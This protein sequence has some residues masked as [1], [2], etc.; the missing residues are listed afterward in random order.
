VGGEYIDWRTWL[1]CDR[2]VFASGSPDPDVDFLDRATASAAGWSWNASSP[3]ASA[4]GAVYSSAHG[5]SD[6]VI[7][8][9]PADSRSAA[10]NISIRQGRWAESWL[11]NCVAIGDSAV[12]I[13]PL[14]W[15]NLHLVH[16]QIDRLVSMMPGCDCAP[17]ELAEYNRQSNAEADRVRDFVCLHYVAARRDEPFWKD[18]ASIEPPESLA[19][20]LALFTERGRLPYYEEETFSRDSWLAVL[21]G[22]GMVPRRTDPLADVVPADEAARQIAIYGDAV[23]AFVAAQPRYH[24]A[25]SHLG[26]HA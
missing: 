21:L 16:S 25:M 22:Q 3:A 10:E 11:R 15:A 7:S 6:A 20:S 19:H 24:E 23:R 9:L 4:H 26:V 1:P 8:A 17:V 2:L 5:S 12:T 14:E 13:E 18:A